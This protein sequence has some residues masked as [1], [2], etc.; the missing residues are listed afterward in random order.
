MCFRE[1][2]CWRPCMR[3]P[4]RW[5]SA[6][7]PSSPPSTRACPP[8]WACWVSSS[9]HAWEQQGLLRC[10]ACL[11]AWR[12]WCPLRWACWVTA[13]L[14]LGRALHHMHKFGWRAGRT[15]LST[16]AELQCGLGGGCRMPHAAVSGCGSSCA[17]PAPCPLPHQPS[18]RCP[19]LFP[20]PPAAIPFIVHPIDAGVHAVLNATLR[21]AMRRY[22][23]QEAG[24]REAGLVI[25]NCEAER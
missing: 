18:P 2:R 4:R 6:T 10:H 24:G 21:P 1:R 9:G 14:L 20:T 16:W 25:C 19:H 23:C 3:Q 7:R 22:I 15:P 12:Q 8:R 11:M 13:G 17:V 5:A